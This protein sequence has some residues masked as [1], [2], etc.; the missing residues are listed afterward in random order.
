MLVCFLLRLGSSQHQLFYGFLDFRRRNLA[1]QDFHDFLEISKSYINLL[2]IYIGFEP[3]S[4]KSENKSPN[5][6]IKIF[7]TELAFL[8][9][10]RANSSTERS[11]VAPKSQK[12][13]M[14]S[15]GALAGLEEAHVGIG[16]PRQLC[17]LARPRLPVAG[18]GLELKM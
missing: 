10:N 7:A 9:F 13:P 15:Q 18:T 14:R 4:E 1:H 6:I 11:E 2:R 5:V 16:A 17:G 12:H 8:F 3:K